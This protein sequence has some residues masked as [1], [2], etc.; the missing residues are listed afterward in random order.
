[1]PH[2]FHARRDVKPAPCVLPESL[3]EGAM[4]PGPCHTY[5]TKEQLCR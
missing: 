5:M 3:T 4:A 1:M 2:I